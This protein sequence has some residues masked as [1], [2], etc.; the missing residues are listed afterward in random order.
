MLAQECCVNCYLE[1]DISWDAVMG[2]NVGVSIDCC[3]ERLLYA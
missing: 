3:A 1:E 2:F